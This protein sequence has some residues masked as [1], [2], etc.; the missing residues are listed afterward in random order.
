MHMDQYQWPVKM[1]TLIYFLPAQLRKSVGVEIESDVF[2]SDWRTGDSLRLHSG[3]WVGYCHL[4]WHKQ[5]GIAMLQIL[6]NSLHIK[7][8]VVF[9]LLQLVLTWA[10]AQWRRGFA[11]NLSIYQT[12]QTLGSVNCQLLQTRQESIKDCKHWSLSTIAMGFELKHTWATERVGGQ[13]ESS[14][15]LRSKELLR[16]SLLPRS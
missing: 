1:T 4:Q 10:W 7:Y 3:G 13:L 12:L 2:W 15:T 14:I 8:A 9:F 11:F 6:C 16:K 5:S